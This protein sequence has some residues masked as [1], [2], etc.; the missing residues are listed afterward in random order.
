[1]RPAWLGLAP[2]YSHGGA[3]TLA[4]AYPA[5]P[6]PFG[7]KLA[8]DLGRILALG[9]QETNQAALQSA[10]GMIHKDVTTRNLQLELDHPC[11]ARGHRGGL[12]I[13]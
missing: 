3:D 1:M 13:G 6:L 11:T 12:N 5:H 10:E 9:V 8:K 2:Y 4:C 7:R